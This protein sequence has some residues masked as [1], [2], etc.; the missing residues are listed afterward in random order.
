MSFTTTSILTTGS[1]AFAAITVAAGRCLSMIRGWM[2]AQRDYRLLCQMDENALRDIGLTSSDL[3]DAT[4]VG[5][6]GDPTRLIACRADERHAR[7][8]P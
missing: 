2:R 7:S 3:R 5:L 1:S 4:A 6:L 8:R